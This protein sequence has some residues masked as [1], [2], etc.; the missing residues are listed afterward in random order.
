MIHES[1]P[2]HHFSISVLD[3]C[4][5]A[6]LSET[7]RT[8]ENMQ[9]KR[10]AVSRAATDSSVGAAILAWLG[11]CLVSG[12]SMVPCFFLLLGLFWGIPKF[13]QCVVCKTFEDSTDRN[14]MLLA[15]FFLMLAI[16]SL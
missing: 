3:L 16:F 6:G 7:Q 8:F 11:L 1:Q 15:V 12:E 4:F 2:F 9:G 14:L 13:W 5:F 10:G